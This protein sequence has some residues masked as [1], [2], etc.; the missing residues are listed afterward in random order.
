LLA[1][2]K[3]RITHLVLEELQ[4]DPHALVPD[5]LITTKT[6]AASSGRSDL[7]EVAFLQL[8]GNEHVGEV[9]GLATRS[10]DAV[11]LDVRNGK[12]DKRGEDVGKDRGSGSVMVLPLLESI[13]AH[14]LVLSRGLGVGEELLVEPP[15]SEV[16]LHAIPQALRS[17]SSKAKVQKSLDDD[18]NALVSASG[19]KSRLVEH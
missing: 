2:I 9:D 17:L 18:A 6:R 1:K 3:E 13:P 7:D 10:G 5:A 11:L 15:R 16:A 19:A 4:V 14:V 8:W 12:G